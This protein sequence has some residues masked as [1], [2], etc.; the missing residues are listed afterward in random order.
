MDHDKQHRAFG[1]SEPQQRKRHPAN[2]RQ[3]LQTKREHA[4]RVFD[5]FRRRRQQ[6]QR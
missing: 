6:S 3:R 2:T 4:D 5:E 1:L